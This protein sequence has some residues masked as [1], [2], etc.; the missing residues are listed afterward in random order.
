MIK[1]TVT[2]DET[3]DF[4]SELIKV[5]AP[6][7]AALIAN[8]VPCNEQM[9]DHPTVQCGEQ[10][11]GFPQLTEVSFYGRNIDFCYYSDRLEILQK[12]DGHDGW[13]HYRIDE[14]YRS[15]RAA[16]T[17]ATQSSRRAFTGIT[18]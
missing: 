12:R 4:L 7:I 17:A 11:G 16:N 2:L 9:A 15:K 10:H 1:E 3:I 13:I 14:L 8:C 6:A 18:K 5:D